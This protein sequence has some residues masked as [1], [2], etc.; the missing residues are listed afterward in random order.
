ME[1]GETVSTE[2]EIVVANTENEDR[3]EVPV[4]DVEKRG[5]YSKTPGRKKK[6]R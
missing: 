3:I 1:T 5:T 6:K 2:T 4:D